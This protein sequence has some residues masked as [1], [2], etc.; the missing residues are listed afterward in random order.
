MRLS[1]DPNITG[2]VVF[3]HGFA[4][5]PVK[6]WIDFQGAARTDFPNWDLYFYGYRSIRSRITACATQ[7]RRF[8][9]DLMSRDFERDRIWGSVSNRALDFEYQRIVVAA[10]S[11][12]AIVVRRAILDQIM[13]DRSEGSLGTSWLKRVLFLLYAP[14]HMGA[15]IIQ[16]GSMALR[17][18]K[19]VPI[20][21]VVKAYAPVL[22]DLAVDSPII[23]QLRDDAVS[24]ATSDYCVA[25]LIPTA[26]VTAQFDQVVNPTRFPIDMPPFDN[27]RTDHVNVCKPSQRF[28]DP[29]RAF[30]YTLALGI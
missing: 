29:M 28:T 3:V 17:P 21:A 8:L 5:H 7:F 20:E 27:L 2:G 22:M 6:T 15:D 4:G 9:C 13:L 25:C 16:L 12:G 14:A 11:A 1:D 18:I 24:I 26:T 19:L 30:L 10:H 23:K